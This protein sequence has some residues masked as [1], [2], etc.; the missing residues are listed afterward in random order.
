[1][2]WLNITST[3]HRGNDYQSATPAYFCL[4]NHEWLNEDREPIHGYAPPPNFKGVDFVDMLR[5][6]DPYSSVTTYRQ[7]H[8]VRS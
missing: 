8:N 7:T 1:M 3:D 2:I 4:E 6:T 5:I